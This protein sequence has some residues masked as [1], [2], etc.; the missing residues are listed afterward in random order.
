MS[1]SLRSLVSLFSV[2]AEHDTYKNEE[3]WTS[4]TAIFSIFGR[5]C[6]KELRANELCGASTKKKKREKSLRKHFFSLLQ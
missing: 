2:L 4:S 5:L 6:E 3:M 1:S